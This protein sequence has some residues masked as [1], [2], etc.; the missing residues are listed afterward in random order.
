MLLASPKRLVRAAAV[1]ANRLVDGAVDL[2]F[3][4]VMRRSAAKLWPE[5]EKAARNPQATQAA[6]LQQILADN[7]STR[8]GREHG[9]ADLAT[10][11]AYRRAVPTQS[12]DSLQRLIERQERSKESTLTS[13]QPVMYAQTSGTSG[14]PKFI[15]ITERGV[16]RLA[17]AQRLF[18]TKVHRSTAM[19]DGK[20]VGIGSPAVE[21]H[22]P[23]G[24]AY[25]SASGL[26]YEGM[27]SLVRRKYAIGPEALAL[28]DH[29]IRY[30]VIAAHC[31]AER[32]VT[33]VAT[34]N[35]STLLRL[36]NVMLAEWDD[37]V[38]AVQHGEFVDRVANALTDDE[39]A[40]FR[41]KLGRRPVRARALRQ[42]RVLHGDR[43]GFAHIW[44]GLAVIATWT[45]GSCGFA[46]DALRPFLLE[47]TIV[48][49]LGYSASEVRGA[50]GIDPRTNQCLPLL[51][52]TFFEFVPRAVRDELSRPLA[53][54]DFLELHELEVGGQYYVWVTTSEGLYRYDMNDIV[55]VTSR[56]EMTPCIAFVQKGR[57]VTNITG[58]KLSE[59][60]V[61]K[62]VADAADALDVTVAF[63]VLLADEVNARYVLC[64]ERQDAGGR[65]QQAVDELAVEIDE[66]LK[67][68]NIEYG[69]KRNS[70]RL[71]VVSAIDLEPGAGEA[72]RRAK[73]S[74]GQRDAQFK[75]LHVQ[76]LND[77]G[78]DFTVHERSSR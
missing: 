14:S 41:Q 23:G 38:H 56:W 17:R 7:A 70:G 27:P 9:F 12:W 45:G 65:S 47:S 33:G 40:A 59:S 30:H 53:P 69:S 73:V 21:G 36:R 61:L 1:L 32:N 16:E 22:L 11:D 8:F 75:Y 72:Y 58:E 77:C 13:A 52:D 63:F 18:T 74:E 28:E 67:A 78:F 50:V 15:P 25:G 44:P 19:F 24:S 29:G 3:D 48:A 55:E 43:L 37:L 10:S 46:I 64:V 4:G 20:L 54:D 51:E 66:R 35:P 42:L 26:V 39:R 57:G 76:L 34:A 62:A 31:L 49:E 71:G 68:L 6:V 60:Q 2:A 5:V